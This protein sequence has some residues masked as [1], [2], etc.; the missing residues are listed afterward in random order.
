[1]VQDYRDIFSKIE[2]TLRKESNLSR[3]GFDSQM[4]EY[5]SLNYK[6]MSDDEIFWK[7]I[8]VIFYSGMNASTVELKLP[9]IRKYLYDF[10]KVKDYSQMEI[11]PFL[12][13]SNTIHNKPKI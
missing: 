11:D 8:C 1:M 3:E 5:K 4:E 12:A 6:K 2:N 7:I 10:R 13:D 9:T